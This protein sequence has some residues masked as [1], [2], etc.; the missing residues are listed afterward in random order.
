MYAI[1]FAIAIL[2]IGSV[3]V[4]GKPVLSIIDMLT[5]FKYNQTIVDMVPLLVIIILGGFAY[6]LVN[7]RYNIL[8]VKNKQK[9][10]LYCYMIMLVIGIVLSWQLTSRF[11]MYGAASSFAGTMFILFALLCMV[12]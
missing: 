5:G 2:G 12:K 3:L 1:A 4:I 7:I 9:P 11:D 10:M 8:A 6:T